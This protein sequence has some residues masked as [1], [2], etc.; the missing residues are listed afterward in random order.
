MRASVAYWRG[1]AYTHAR[2]LDKA[3]A[4]L[5]QVL[6]PSQGGADDPQR[7]SV[8]Y[9]AWQ[10]VLLGHGELHR[11]VGVPQLDQPGRRLEAIAAVERQL[12]ENPEDSTGWDL[13]RLLYQDVTEAQYNRAAPGADLP[14]SYFDHAYAQQLGLALINDTA[15]WQRGGEFLRLAARGLPALGPSLFIQIAQAHQRAGDGEGAWRNYELA[16]R[17]ALAVGPKNLADEERQAYFATVK[18]LGEAALAHDQVDRAIE[19]FQLYSESERSG[20]ETL[21][22][23]AG[24]YERKGQVLAALRATEQALVFNS[25]DPDLLARKDRYYYSVDPQFVRAHPDAVPG[26]FDVAYCLAKARSVLNARE[27]DLDALD[28]GQHLADLACAVKPDNI[29]ARVL[30]ARAWIRRGEKEKAAALLQ[31]LHSPKPE[32]FPSEEEEEAWYQVCRLL[33]DLYLYDLSRPDLAIACYNDYRKSS[34]SGAD[35]A[36]KLGQAYEAAGDRA[37]AIKCYELVISFEGHPLAPDA[38]EGLYRLQSSQ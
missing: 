25:K 19:N 17:A 23:L 8:L 34:K 37:R 38:R 6:D 11:R 26:G 14:V 22:T 1:V 2:D 31:E 32:K 20:L 12:A 18:L 13:K 7:Q 35:T 9:S 27:L 24:L 36:Y 15:R 29:Q 5:D 4:E 33:G 28:W 10:L 30:L 16:K 21:R 3:A